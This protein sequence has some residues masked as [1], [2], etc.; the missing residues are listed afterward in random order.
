MSTETLTKPWKKF[1]FSGRSLTGDAMLADASGDTV[2]DLSDVNWTQI[3]A[4]V[5]VTTLAGTSIT[6]KLI[7]GNERALI[8]TTG[9]VATAANGS[10][11]LQTAFLSAANNSILATGRIATDGSTS[12]NIGQYL[13]VFV[14]AA[15]VLTAGDIDV[16]V[17][18]R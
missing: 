7:T 3:N 12:S 4:Q 5:N 6:V 15:G 13:G 14:D 17:F 11:A 16:T 8:S 10:T 2:M 1:K 9:V 18:V